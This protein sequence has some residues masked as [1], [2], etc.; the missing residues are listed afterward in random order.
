MSD[1]DEPTRGRHADDA[2]PTKI[3]TD[4]LSGAYVLNALSDDERHAFEELLDDTSDQYDDI[5]TEVAE[6]RETALLLAH[7]ARPVTP[8]AELRASVL[9]L[10]ASTP[11]L[12]P[13]TATTPTA[14]H[15]ATTAGG[16][17]D[18]DHERRVERTPA[19]EMEPSESE[20][21]RV[22]TATGAAHRRWFARPVA[23]LGAAAAAAAL[24]FGGGALVEGLGQTGQQQEQQAS[25]IDEIYAASDFQ[26]SV[27][28]VS[29]GGK[30]TLIWSDELGR[31]AVVVDGMTSLPGDQTYELWY[32][33]SD[34]AVPAG[35][36]DASSSAPATHLLKGEK[37]PGD[38]I[39]ITVEPS[40]GSS[41]PT[42]DP[43][44]AIPSA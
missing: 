16:A 5:R 19:P 42:T 40:G 38:T 37:S 9:G 22:L 29:T 44:V 34:G 17:G 43:V 7:A 30:A 32:I 33:G 10:I 14:D 36:F 15:G 1:H 11:Q 31:S 21:A 20:G 27:A 4:D 23:I 12:P 6:L 25:G 8:S 13:L 28:D 24:F 26:R 41:S 35:T 3:D 2:G 39:G 18:G